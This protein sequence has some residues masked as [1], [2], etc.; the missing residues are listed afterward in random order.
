[1]GF[2]LV[3]MGEHYVVDLL[4]G[5]AVAALAWI[6]AS[7]LVSADANTSESA[8]S[9]PAPR[10]D[11]GADDGARPGLTTAHRHEIE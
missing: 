10:D 11:H 5:A 3:F 7:K 4:V 2:V 1:M 8:V 9:S 6:A